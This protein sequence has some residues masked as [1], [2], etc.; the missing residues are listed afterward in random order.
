MLL[1]ALVTA[2]AVVP[3]TAIGAQPVEQFHDHFTDSFSDE[4]CG[5]PV[6]V[7]IVV[8]DNFFVYAE[9]SFKDTASVRATFTNPVNGNLVV[10]SNAG[11]VSGPPPIIDEDAG[12]I[13]FLTNFKGLSEKIQ[14]ASGAGL[15]P[16]RRLCPGRG[17]LRLGDGRF[18]LVRGRLR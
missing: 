10:I 8:T 3:G 1:A 7:E 11:Q 5:I 6:N 15:S 18:H 17:H 13:T 14:T 12:T 2:L 16:R 9:E 4:L